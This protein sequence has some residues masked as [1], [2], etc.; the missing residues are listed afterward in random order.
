M[1]DGSHETTLPFLTIMLAFNMWWIL[2]LNIK[3]LVVQGD[4]S[5]LL[6]L[7]QKGLEGFAEGELLTL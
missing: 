5:W 7:G 4:M 6:T 1:W 2:Y 3:R